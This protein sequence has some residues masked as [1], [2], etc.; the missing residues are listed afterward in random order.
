MD[1]VDRVARELQSRMRY[2]DIDVFLRGHGVD[3]KKATSGANS[4]W[5][6]SKELLDGESDATILRIADEIGVPHK[7]AVADIS[8]AVEASFWEPLHFRLFL[9]HL[10]VFKK[11]TGLL[12]TALR[13]YGI[14]AFVAHVDIEPTR[15][16]Q[17]EIE[18]GL[19]TMDALAAVLMPGFKESNWTDQ[20]VGFA[21]GRG[22]LVVP[23]IRGL[24]PY[25]FIS[26]YQGMHATGKTISEVATELFTIIV[27]SPR[28]RSRMLSALV[29]TTLR[30]VTEANAL[31]KLGHLS[32]VKD[33]PA[34][35]LQQLRDGAASSAVLSKGSP[36]SALDDLLVKYKLQPVT[37]PKKVVEFD[38]D[39]PF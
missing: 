34:A 23:I 5:V 25:G 10:A 2:A 12:Q 16:W 33:V 32:R 15:E 18:A 1:L 3:T 35:Y 24:N 31:E 39:I 9:S 26:K 21:V 4:K 28:T 13:G 30:S 17:N 7:Y 38:D 20:E 14:S 8:K 11:T 6:Y 29:E 19:Q 27:K 22:V 36:L 37:K